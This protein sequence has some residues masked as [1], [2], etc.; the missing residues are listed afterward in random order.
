MSD[1]RTRLKPG[2]VLALVVALVLFALVLFVFGGN[3][4][5]PNLGN[6]PNQP[7]SQTTGGVRPPGDSMPGIPVSQLPSEARQVLREIADGGPFQYSQDG[8][9]FMNLQHLLPPEPRGYYKEYTVP[10]PGSPDRGARRIIQ[11]QG[12]ELYYTSDHYASFRT[13]QGK[14]Q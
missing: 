11:G 6:N 9:T 7:S 4:H 14:S 5:D 10:T 12:G 2:A 8:S 1:Q 3:S 13:I